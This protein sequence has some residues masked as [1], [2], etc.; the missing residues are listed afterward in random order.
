LDNLT[1]QARLAKVGAVLNLV[2]DP[3]TSRH[4]NAFEVVR[5]VV[6]NLDYRSAQRYL[7]APGVFEQTETLNQINEIN[8]MDA[9]GEVHPVDRADD[10]NLHLQVLGQAIE[11]AQDDQGK[12][13]L[14]QGHAAL[15]MSFLGQGGALE[16]FQQRTGAQVEQSGHR[17]I[18]V[19]PQQQPPQQGEEVP[20]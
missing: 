3:V 17:L 8:V 14:L 6:E 20:A 2:K 1:P 9:I 15:H 12:Q 13:L 10:H 4:L 16:E 11:A 18:M 7:Q 5:D 19:F